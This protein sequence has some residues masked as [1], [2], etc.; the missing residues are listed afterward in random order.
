MIT[1]CSNFG[2]WF[3]SSLKKKQAEKKCGDG[4]QQNYPAESQ[5]WRRSC[6]HAG[7]NTENHNKGLYYDFSW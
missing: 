1:F 7:R 5:C 4:S 2:Q 6:T 3:S